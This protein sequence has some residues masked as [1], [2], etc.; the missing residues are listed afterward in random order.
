MIECFGIKLNDI[1]F[2][3]F[4]IRVTGF[5]FGRCNTRPF[6]V[7]AELTGNVS[8]NVLV[9]LKTK[10][11]LA[12]FGKRLVAAFAGFFEFDVR[13]RYVAWTDQFFKQAF[14]ASS[15]RTARQPGQQ[16]K[17]HCSACR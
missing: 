3:A 10:P 15:H 14:R 5:A 8:R 4:V 11:P 1:K 17:D 7:E 13:V 2:A 9:T 6:T 12:F 16:H